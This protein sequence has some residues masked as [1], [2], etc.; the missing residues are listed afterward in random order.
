LSGREKRREYEKELATCATFKSD[1]NPGRLLSKTVE[2]AERERVASANDVL[3]RARTVPSL[4]NIRTGEETRSAH[5][6][7]R[8][9]YRGAVCGIYEC[10]RTCLN[11]LRHVETRQD[12]LRRC[13]LDLPL[14]LSHPHSRTRR[15][16]RNNKAPTSGTDGAPS[17]VLITRRDDGD[18][19][20][21][22][23]Q[24]RTN[25]RARPGPRSPSARDHNF[26]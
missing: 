19:F 24:P 11:V 12:T 10:V 5:Q 2:N 9:R 20:F 4:Y 23:R 16:R 7:R 15:I 17:R 18:F 6:Q 21:R 25:F 8:Q 26:M 13:S 1:L 14:S 3:L 22:L